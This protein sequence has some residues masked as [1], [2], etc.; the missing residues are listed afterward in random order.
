M[1]LLIVTSYGFVG[2]EIPKYIIN[3]IIEN[4]YFLINVISIKS[5]FPIKSMNN[6]ANQINIRFFIMPD[7]IAIS[8]SSALFINVLLVFDN[9]SFLFLL[10]ALLVPETVFLPFTTVYASL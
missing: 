10:L 9:I 4:E 8:R 6:L 3:G 5:S 2:N 7:G 1:G